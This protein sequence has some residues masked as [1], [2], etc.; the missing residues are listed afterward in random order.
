MKSSAAEPPRSSSN[1]PSQ[2]FGNSAAI[3]RPSIRSTRIEAVCCRL[4]NPVTWR[5][6]D[7]TKRPH[8]HQAGSHGPTEN[9]LLAI[10]KSP[11]ARRREGQGSALDPLGGQAPGPLNKIEGPGARPLVGSGAK[12]R[13]CRCWLRHQRPRR[14]RQGLAR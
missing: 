1:I 12:P 9:S 5:Q 7:A 10:A 3:C 14:I 13:P 8:H 4:S 2:P 11:C 6:I